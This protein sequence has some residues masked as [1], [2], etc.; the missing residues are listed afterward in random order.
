V[1]HGV[2]AAVSSCPVLGLLLGLTQC[3]REAVSVSVVCPCL[4][5]LTLASPPDGLMVGA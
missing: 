1:D 5:P 3:P 4:V 2:W